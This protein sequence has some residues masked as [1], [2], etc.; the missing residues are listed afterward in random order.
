[1]SSLYHQVNVQNVQKLLTA[2]QREIDCLYRL[3]YDRMHDLEDSGPLAA[4]VTEQAF[5]RQW[6]ELPEGY[7]LL[8]DPWF[9]DNVA[10]II[11]EEDMQIRPEWFRG[12]RVLD[13][14]CGNGRWS[15]GLAQL[16]AN[17]TAVDVS[18]VSIE[19]TKGA[20][21]EFDVGKR[22]FVSPLED[23]WENLPHEDYDLVFS[24]GVIHHVRRFNA[25]FDAVTRFVAPNGVLFLYL[26]GRES[27]AYG[28]DIRMFKDRIFYNTRDKQADRDA[29]LDEKT[30][31]NRAWHHSKHDVY[32][33]L[34]NRRLEFDYV[35][36]FLVKRGF[37]DIVRTVDHTELFVRAFRDD[38][39]NY[40][41]NWVLPKKSPPYWFQRLA[42][43]TP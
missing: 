22:F 18:P 35:R 36:D 24:W 38:V 4:A 29:F 17:I 14:G 19:K 23:L 34:I 10:R 5:S 8:T 26:Y 31:G 12:K 1:V 28:D 2:Q 3:V 27:L 40:Y 9:K 30:G 20:L 11:S 13:A 43:Q 37:K 16:G 15:Y 21:A 32:A 42:D 25:A 7:F 33:P 41:M 39:D 6:N